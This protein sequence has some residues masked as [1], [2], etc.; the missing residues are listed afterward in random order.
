[1]AYAG[2]LSLKKKLQSN[3]LGLSWCLPGPSC[4]KLQDQRWGWIPEPLD[5]GQG[6]P[7]AAFPGKFPPLSWPS[8]CITK[9]R[10][11][12]GLGSKRQQCRSKATCMVEGCVA[13]ALAGQ[14]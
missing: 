5:L 4:Q 9:R 13:G 8:E 2:Q 7:Q 6:P 1:M 11:E 12:S 14:T 10:E 3:S